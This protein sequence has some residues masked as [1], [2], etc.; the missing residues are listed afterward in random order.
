MKVIK[1]DGTLVMYE[2]W[3]KQSRGGTLPSRY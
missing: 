1:K 3:E 2:Q